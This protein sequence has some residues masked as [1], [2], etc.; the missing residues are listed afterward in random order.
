MKCIEALNMVSDFIN[1]VLISIKA[2]ALSK[3]LLLPHIFRIPQIIMFL[4]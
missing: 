3:D 1:D 2:E 4:S